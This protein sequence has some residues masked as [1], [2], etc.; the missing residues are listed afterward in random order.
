MVQPEVRGHRRYPVG[1]QD[2]GDLAP[3]DAEQFTISMDRSNDVVVPLDHPHPWWRRVIRRL[4][5]TT[6][7]R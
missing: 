7:S 2:S 1:G 5:G 4:L 6:R 3:K